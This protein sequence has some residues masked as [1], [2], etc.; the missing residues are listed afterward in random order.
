MI[1]KLF[2]LL[3]FF[4][5]LRVGAPRASKCSDMPSKYLMLKLHNEFTQDEQYNLTLFTNFRAFSDLFILDCN[6]TY[7]TPTEYVEFAPLIPIL[8]NASFSLDKI[9]NST[10]INSI[11]SLQLASIMG[12]DIQYEVAIK[13]TKPIKSLDL[14]MFFSKLD[15]YSNGHLLVNESTC[16]LA[17]FN[18]SSNFF[19]PF[20]GV[21]FKRVIYPKSLC[22]LIFWRTHLSEVRFGDITN[23]F[24]EKNRLNFTHIAHIKSD[25]LVKVFVLQLELYQERLT[26]SLMIKF[27]FRH[28]F[29]LKIYG[30]VDDI[31]YDLFKDFSRLQNID[32]LISD[33]KGL[34]HKGNKWLSHLNS[35]VNVDLSNASDIESHMGRMLRLRFQYPKQLVSFDT[36]YDYPD[37][38]LCYFKNF[39]HHRLVYPIVVPGRNI[40]CTCTLVW[41]KY[42]SH[43]YEPYSMNE[44][45]DYALNYQNYFLYTLQLTYNFCGESFNVSACELEKRLNNCE[46]RL[47]GSYT[48]RRALVTFRLENDL[49]VYYF[50]KFFEL[51]LLVFLQ[52]VLCLIG[53][54]SNV[55]VFVIITN[56]SRKKEFS[57]PMYRHI[58]INAVF[59]VLYCGILILKL[60]NTCT[61]FNTEFFCSAV[62]QTDASQ[63][64]KACIFY[65]CISWLS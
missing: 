38:D 27:L 14:I 36:V 56:K 5:L 8:V 12:V 58:L 54:L 52:P 11:Q 40:N 63:W 43:L 65:F 16:E 59:N 41:L 21:L 22:P 62:Y 64:F 31:Q 37:E 1:K 42:Y 50:V 46:I 45:S 23:S 13:Q 28:L 30:I 44:T 4:I 10:Q 24:L 29:E 47:R 6:Q 17:T 9:L 53:I 48:E 34:F 35:E 7:D 60:V 2:E 61:S 15:I 39:P 51:I 57:D 18:N 20:L 26:S 49:D 25:F 32:L 55:G 3:I 19:E 33:F